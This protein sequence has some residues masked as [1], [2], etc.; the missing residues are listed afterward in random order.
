MKPNG[1]LTVD[2][3][4]KHA[5]LFQRL[6]VLRYAPQHSLV[7][8]SILALFFISGLFAI[9]G[10]FTQLSILVFLV[11]TVSIQSRTFVTHFSGA[12]YIARSLL[13]CLLFANCGAALSMDATLFSRSEAMVPGWPIRLIQIYVCVIYLSSAIQ[14]CRCDFWRSGEAMRNVA[15]SVMWSRRLFLETLCK[16]WV[17]K[18]GTYAVVFFEFLAPFTFWFPELRL[19]TLVV[20][21]LFHLGVLLVMR[22]GYFS[23]LMIAAVLSFAVQF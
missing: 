1:L 3:Y 8:P 2:D 12:D 19:A 13:L 5:G 14:K 21:V 18:F 7:A 22:I 10:L 16:V 20:A 9:L 11:C 4:V 17:Y 23:P 15:V 6:S